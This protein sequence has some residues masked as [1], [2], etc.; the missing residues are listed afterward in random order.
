MIEQAIEICKADPKQFYILV[1]LTDGDVSD[2]ELDMK[3][4]IKASNYP[5]EIIAIGFG[6]GPFKTMKIF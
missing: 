4:L 2:V 6:D 1:I 5:L 3:A